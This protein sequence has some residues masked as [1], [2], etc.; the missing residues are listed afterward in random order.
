VKSPAPVAFVESIEEALIVARRTFA[1]SHHLWAVYLATPSGEIVVDRAGRVTSAADFDA[2][3]WA[4]F[5]AREAK[6][7]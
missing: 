3:Q 7:V 5:Q 2:V 4:R 1:L 6:A